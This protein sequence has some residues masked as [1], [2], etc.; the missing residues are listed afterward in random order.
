[1]FIGQFQRGE[2]IPLHYQVLTSGIAV[3]PGD[4]ITAKIYGPAGT[5]LSTHYLTP[6][7]PYT[8]VGLFVGHATATV[9]GANMVVY[10]RVST[11]AK[12]VERFTVL[13]GN[14]SSRGT[15]TAAHAFRRPEADYVVF[16][17]E[18][19]VVFSG[20]NPR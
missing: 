6:L 14:S 17:T 3:A 15:V 11:N 10:E 13:G 1:M 7:N 8:T 4:Q 19:G 12:L 20:R 5:L 2:L 9:Q 16:Q 18:H